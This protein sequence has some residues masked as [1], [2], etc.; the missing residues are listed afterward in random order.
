LAALAS[1]S[2]LLVGCVASEKG[3]SLIDPTETVNSLAPNRILVPVNQVLTPAGLQVELPGLRPQVLALSPDGKLLVTSGK[4]HELILVDPVAGTILQRV[5]LPSEKVHEQDAG[6]VSSRVLDPDKEGQV[7][8]TGLVFSPDGARIFLSNVNGSIKVFAV[9]PDHRA[10]G[11]YSIR[12]PKTGLSYRTND[13]PSGLAISSDGQRLYVALNVSN[14]LLELD[15]TSGRPLRFFEVGTAPYAVVLA[16]RKAY[17]SN[18]GGRRAGAQGVNGPI[19]IGALVRVDAV[20]FIA[21]EG[22]VSVVDLEAGRVSREI[23]VGLHAS[24]LALP[25]DGRYLVVANANS[26][27]V[28]AIDTRTDQVVE[29]IPLRWQAHDL[30]G[31]SPN[32]LAFDHSGK[33]L[34]VCNGTQNAVAV[35]SF[36]PG[37]SKLLGLIPTGWYPGAIVLDSARRSIYVA[38]IK[39][40]GT[41]KRYAPTENVKFNSHQYFGTLSLVPLPDQAQLA[42]DTRIVLRNYQRA[43]AQAALLPPRPN[44]PPRPVPERVGEPSVFKHVVYIIKENRSYDQV[45]GDLREGNGDP[46]LCV[47]G[48]EVTPNQHKICREF[49]LLDNTYCSGI[50]SADGH[51]WTDTAFATDYMEKSFAG[52]PRSYPDGMDDGGLD[53][54]AYAPTGFIWDNALEHGK[55]LRDYGEFSVSVAGWRDPSKKPA[56]KFLDYYHD[57]TSQSGLTRVGSRPGLPS[58]AP[59]VNTNTVGWNLAVPDIFRAAEFIRELRQFERDGQFPDFVI[60]CLPND[61]TSGTKPRSPTPD[62]Q[63][64]DNDLAFGQIVEAVAHSRFWKDTCIFAI[65]D[66]PQNGWD[67]VSGYRTTAYVVSPYTARH[68]VVRNNYNQTSI[69]R[70]MELILGLPPMN[71]M[72]ASATPMFACFSELADLTQYTAVP[73]KVPLDQLNPDVKAIR[74][75]VQRKYAIA[76]SKLPLQDA[77]ECPED[78][79]NRILWHAQKG[80]E[81]PYPTWAVNSTR[82]SGP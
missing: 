19:G 24:G 69:L 28:S 43:A 13:I 11:L 34:Y 41:G 62:A 42:R 55:T 61:H 82:K 8:Y 50:L 40:I 66:D 79:L 54:L 6:A 77:D 57:F 76:S 37:K 17:V 64:A 12:L 7:S 46:S 31:A 23:A 52:F 48:E 45:L 75:P 30:F 67:H 32:A 39:G 59:Y 25:L 70:T 4:T 16:G 65:E 56:P 81:M 58:L 63:V 36:R 71:Q 26:D 38:N 73:N 15:S 68:T 2:A 49:V 5:P 27:T 33:N 20:R 47:F 44:V 60:V 51:Q 53:A 21:N 29:T 74:D 80:S 72:D 14:R 3:V 9:G 10:R 1:L 18:W 78:L 22:S 35:V